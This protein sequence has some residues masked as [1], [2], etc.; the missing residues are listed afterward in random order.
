MLPNRRMTE[1]VFLRRG[2]LIWNSHRRIFF[3]SKI[4]FHRD[5]FLATSWV[6][7]QL[8]AHVA[9][10]H[11]FYAMQAWTTCEFCNNDDHFLCFWASFVGF[12]VSFNVQCHHILEVASECIKNRIRGW[13]QL[14]LGVQDDASYFFWQ[15]SSQRVSEPWHLIGV[16]WR[17]E[18]YNV[19]CKIVTCC[20][21]QH[22]TL[23]P[24]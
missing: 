11:D 10:G 6:F 7:G 4:C 17:W 20:N 23:D 18:L 12:P 9:R 19:Y 24:S 2:I 13:T 8:D 15:S 14:C 3:V 21:K 1:N 16:D 22:N 5:F